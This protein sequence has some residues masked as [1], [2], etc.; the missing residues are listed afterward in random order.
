M[1]ESFSLSASVKQRSV[2]RFEKPSERKGR[3]STPPDHSLP[4]VN[5]LQRSDPTVFVSFR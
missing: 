4:Y 3:Q 1:P 2:S 5:T